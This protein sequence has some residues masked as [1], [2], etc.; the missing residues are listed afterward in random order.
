MFVHIQLSLVQFN[1]FVLQNKK[2]AKYINVTKKFSKVQE[3]SKM[4]IRSSSQ[5]PP[6]KYKKCFLIKKAQQY[7]HKTHSTFRKMIKE[8]ITILV[9]IN[10]S[11]FFLFVIHLLLI[12]Y[13]QVANFF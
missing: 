9:V 8:L 4:T 11:S 12:L 13:H 6:S 2:Y 5:L 3:G 10:S 7:T 1:R